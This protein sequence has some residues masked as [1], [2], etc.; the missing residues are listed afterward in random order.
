M[1]TV[2]YYISSD[3]MEPPAGDMHYSE[4]L[5]RLP[6]LSIWYIPVESEGDMSSN[7]VIPRLEKHDVMFLC[8]QNLLKY[9]PRYDHVFPAIAGQVENVRF[10][11]IASQVAE[12]TEKFMRRLELEFQRQGLHAADYVS[13][14]S[15]LDEADFSALN[16]RADIFLDSI[17]WSG[18]N[19]VFES[20]P[21]NKPIV[22]LPGSFMRGR[23]A[24]AILKMMGIEETIAANVEEFI[25]LAVRLANDKQWQEEISAKIYRNKHLIYRDSACI[26]ALE[27]FFTG[28]ISKHSPDRIGDTWQA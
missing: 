5:V 20:L 4:K 1:P 11:F 19:T 14:V 28:V 25:A 26:A 2:D 16:A 18:C 27:R 13:V 8:C 7:L 6:N 10:V 24:Y 17:E 23:H 15:H 22:T 3:L 21:F 9:L 12:L